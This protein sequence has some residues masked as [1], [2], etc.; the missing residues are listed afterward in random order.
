MSTKSIQKNEVKFIFHANVIYVDG[1][2]ENNDNDDDK[3][4][5]QDEQ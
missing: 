5:N 2:D 4:K 3:Y 1:Y